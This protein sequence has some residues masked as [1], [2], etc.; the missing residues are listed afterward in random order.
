MKEQKKVLGKGLG[1]LLGELPDADS[2][3]KPIGYL[4]KEVAGS[5]PAQRTADVLM[6]P[7]EKI[8]PN[9]YQPRL[10]FDEARL[11]ELSQ[12]IKVLGL[13]QPITVRRCEDGKYQIISGE[14][15]FKA[16]QRAGMDMIPAYVREADTQ[17]M[18]EM[19]IV[20]NIQREDLD[21]IELA[22][23]YSS[24][25]QECSLTQEQMS[26]RLGKKR[27]SIANYLRLLKLPDKVQHDLREGLISV[28][29]AKVLLGVADMDLQQKLCDLVIKEG[30][31]VRDLEQK[32]AQEIP[33]AYSDLAGKVQK[34]FSGNVSFHRNASGTGSITIR[35]GSDDEVEQFLKKLQ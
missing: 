2:L 28:G 26:E 10:E 13:I 9:P 33:A 16:C 32:V 19:S 20:E 24:L 27:T 15:R 31:S 17:G 7:A 6:V 23:S 18:L 22:L 12:S 3:R 5:R 25:M 29:H 14:R 35:F 34:F 1:A 11:E 4:N 30:L 8:E 21:P